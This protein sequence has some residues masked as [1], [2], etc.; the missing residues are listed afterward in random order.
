M[1]ADAGLSTAQIQVMSSD[2]S[3]TT[4]AR[5]GK[6]SPARRPLPS[7]T[8]PL[9]GDKSFHHQSSTGVQLVS[10]SGLKAASDSFP[11]QRVSLEALPLKP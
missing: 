8:V 7:N 5:A 4:L 6:A 11:Y 3:V 2:S 1:C 10:E 9:P